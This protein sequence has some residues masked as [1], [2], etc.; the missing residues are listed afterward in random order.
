M[1]RE[2]EKLKLWL[3]L[4]IGEH[5]ET[6]Q[7]GNVKLGKD[8]SNNRGVLFARIEESAVEASNKETPRTDAGEKK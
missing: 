3:P 7:L 2:K 5:Q 8:R 1:Q 6:K 4:V